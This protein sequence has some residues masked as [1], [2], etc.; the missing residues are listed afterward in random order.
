MPIG[1]SVDREYI[2][3]IR[4]FPAVPPRAAGQYDFL[5]PLL[6]DTGQKI[7]MFFKKE[8]AYFLFQC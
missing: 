7:Q 5:Y 4:S 2:S 3:E 6:R 8:L 1:Y